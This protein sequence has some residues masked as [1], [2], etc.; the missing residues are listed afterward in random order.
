MTGMTPSEVR[1]RPVAVPQRGP[2]PAHRLAAA[3]ALVAALA[4]AVYLLIAAISRWQVLLGG[5]ALLA[6]LVLGGWYALSRT[7]LRRTLGLLLVAASLVA[8]LVLLTASSSFRVL[9]VAG[10]LGICSVLAAGYALTPSASSGSRGATAVRAEHPVLLM[11]PRSGGGKVGRYQLV[12]RCQALGIEPVLLRP[13]DD[14]V[15]LVESAIARGADL[16]GMAGGD[17]SQALVASVASR[18]GVPMVVVPAGTRNH[19][20][21]DLGLNR[22]DVPGALAA[23]TD[24][25]DRVIDLAEVNGRVFV[26]NASMGAY[27]TVVQSSEY[28]DA[29]VAT[30]AAMLPDILGPGATP[31]DLRFGLPSGQ[32]AD[33]AVLLLVS[34]NPY[35]LQHLRGGGVRSQLD[36]GTLG[37]VALQVG[38]PLDLQRLLALEPLGQ[39]PRFPGWHEWEAAEFEVASASPVPIGVDG[40]ALTM[41]PPLRFVSRPRALT[42]RLPRSA[43][44]GGAAAPVYLTSGSTFGLLWQLML[45]HSA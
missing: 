37:V 27:A 3:G 17:G 38:G 18:H 33:T 8:L 35:R 26:N 25:V 16:V 1:S 24:G 34:N 9:A 19:F 36:G 40:E 31:A 22:D 13:G 43:A 4:G 41:Q 45:G 39:L 44:S 15:T 7:G 2:D 20:A 42:V 21:L 30:T 14:L 5:L 11:N 6:A 23:Y 12:D 10:G 32:R 28:R 29:K